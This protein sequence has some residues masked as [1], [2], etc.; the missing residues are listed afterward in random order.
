M[1]VQGMTKRASVL[2]AMA[3]VLVMVGASS[4]QALMF[5]FDPLTDG[6]SNSSIQTYMNN[7]LSA[8]HP[9][10]S[11]TVTGA[12]GEK[13]YTG[14]NH[15]VGPVSGQTVTSET[16]GTS[17]GG[18]HHNGAL[19][20]FLVNPSTTDRIT[21]LFN[22]PIYEVSFD[23]EIFPDATTPDWH[24]SNPA[25][26]SWPDF[27]FK[28]DNA[29]V[30]YTDGLAPGAGG[31]LSHSPFSGPVAN[32]L[33]PQFLGQ[34]GTWTFANGVTKLEFVDWPVRIGIDNLRLT[35]WRPVPEPSSLVLVGLGGLAAVIRRRRALLLSTRTAA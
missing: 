33:A 14:D 2:G 20:T 3:V 10:G 8:Q 18:V 1:G 17:N 31:T 13:D 25:N 16:L 4:A 6:A 15:V 24:N 9:G 27:T 22:F 11:V 28:A 7:L 34:S 23:Y 19:D 26:A 32:E 5:D 35:D 12:V 29:T 21:M 30:F